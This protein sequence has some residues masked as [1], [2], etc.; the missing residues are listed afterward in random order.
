LAPFCFLLRFEIVEH[1]QDAVEV[2][3]FFVES[4]KGAGKAH[5]V[6][7]IVPLVELLAAGEGR[8]PGVEREQSV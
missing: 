1:R 5:R 8:D 2:G 7:R 4:V 6:A 3:I